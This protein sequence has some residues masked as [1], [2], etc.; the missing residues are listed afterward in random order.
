MTHRAPAR[1]ACALIGLLLFTSLSFGAA[2]SIYDSPALGFRVTIPTGWS[3]ADEDVDDQEVMLFVVNPSGDG[4]LIVGAGPLEGA[5]RAAYESGGV[6]ALVEPGFALVASLQNARTVDVFTAML[7]GREAAGFTYQADGIAG[8][9]VMVVSG[10]RIYALGSLA[11]PS[12]EASAE[13]ALQSVL[14]SFTLTAAGAS[15]QGTDPFV[16]VFRGDGLTLT[17][18][19]APD[20]SYAG[21]VAQGNN[22]FPLTATAGPAGLQ[23][24]FTSGAD[25]FAFELATAG[26]TLMFTTGGTR[27]TLGR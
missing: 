8:R 27:Y 21:T 9:F 7:G 19:R 14:D 1:L 10:E 13:A 17:I 18:E 12:G 26:D 6:T 25:A 16:G 11:E 24:R 23:G 4:G 15:A 3:I 5:E 22:A 20:G 2:Q